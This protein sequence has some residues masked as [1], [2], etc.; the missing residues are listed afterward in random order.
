[1][2]HTPGVTS[3]T[4]ALTSPNGKVEL[5]TVYPS[6]GPQARQTF[7]LV[8]YLRDDLIPQAAHG[9]SLAVHVGG[10]TAANI[11]FAHV[12]TDKLPVFIAV[13]VILAF[14]LL[15][16]VFRSLLIPLVAS[17]M[18]L[19]SV[20][21]ALGALNAV[22]NWGWGTRVLG[23]SGTGPIDSFV[24]VIM[25]SVL[26]GLSMDYLVYLVSRIQEEWHQLHH[27]PSDLA[28]LSGRGARRNHQA[29]TVGLASSGRIIA[30]AAS[31]M[32]LVFGSFLLGGH[33]ILQEFGF[34]LAFSVLV[35]ALI[36]R[37]LLVPALMHLLGPANWSLPAWLDR[38]LP[39]LALESTE[40]GPG[41][42]PGDG[43][44]PATL[45]QGG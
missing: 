31:I 26:F 20:G 17:V 3:V 14:I 21:A 32:I 11:D 18:N 38:A 37:G 34:A 22:F 23:L 43:K 40:D 39:R 1:V 25:F 13:V 19:L 16:V 33:R 30:G 24:P 7:D 27:S 8:N 45:S 41:A 28:G 29:I 42:G 5:A 9:T 4:P 10:V 2:A 44:E 36:I 35:D 6:S 15:L 12:L